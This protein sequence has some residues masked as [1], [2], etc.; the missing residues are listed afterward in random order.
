[1]MENNA[2]IYYFKRTNHVIGKAITMRKEKLKD[3][4]EKEQ[5]I[6]D[7]KRKIKETTTPKEK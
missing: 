1:M 7:I 4:G 5:G 2:K 6:N 3:D